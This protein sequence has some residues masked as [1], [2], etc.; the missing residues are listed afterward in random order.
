MPKA[1]W[2]GIVLAESEHCEKVEGKGCC[3]KHYR[4]CGV[5]EERHGRGVGPLS[6]GSPRIYGSAQ[7]TGGCRARSPAQQLGEGVSQASILG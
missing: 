1:T 5:R 7:G 6:D 3:P 4:A 2:N